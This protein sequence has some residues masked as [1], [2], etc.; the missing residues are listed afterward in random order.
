MRKV[1]QGCFVTGTDTGVGKTLVTAGLALCLRQRGC[2]VGVMKPIETGYERADPG[3]SD[4]ERL[5]KAAGCLDPMEQIAPYRL[6]FPAAPLA[7]ARRAGIQID[8]D[9]I[10]KEFQALSDRHGI[11]LVEGVGG[12]VVPLTENQTVLDLIARLA[13]PTLVVGRSLL[14]GVNHALL[15][16]MALRNR[17]LSVLGL[18][19]NRPAELPPDPEAQLLEASTVGLVR[20]LGGLP[21]AGPLPHVPGLALE[22]EAGLARIAREPAMQFVADLLVPDRPEGGGP[23][24]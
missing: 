5:Q 17:G 22:W 3:T 6:S 8:L 20:E 9:R 13:L 4:G 24:R 10:L 7:A 11:L 18:V 12:V 23:L 1:V 15:T 19:L 14:G 16:V 2:P 21:V